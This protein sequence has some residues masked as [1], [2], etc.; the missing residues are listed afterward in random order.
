MASARQSDRLLEEVVVSIIGATIFSYLLV[1]TLALFQ[2]HYVGILPYSPPREAPLFEHLWNQA[3]LYAPVSVIVIIDAFLFLFLIKQFFWPIIGND[4]PSFR[5][6]D[7]IAY[8]LV[9]V[10]ASAIPWPIQRISTAILIEKENLLIH[11]T[12]FLLWLFATS[13]SIFVAW[14]ITF[15]PGAMRVRFQGLLRSLRQRLSQ[16]D[17]PSNRS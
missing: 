10:P 6:R 15:G 3:Q 12:P 2:E 13:I 7:I 11:I 14:M 9:I 4:N 8:L 5:I 17:T 16:N 1:V